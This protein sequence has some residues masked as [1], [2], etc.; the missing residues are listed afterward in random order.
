MNERKISI[1]PSSVG[2]MLFA[3]SCKDHY[4]PPAVKN[5][6]T[7]LVVDGLLTSYPDTAS[8]TLTSTRNLPDSTP[9][10]P[11]LNTSVLEAPGYLFTFLYESNN[12]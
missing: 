8:I 5:N 9:G 6:P 4:T 10:Q 11:E 12:G 2:I 3:E 7:Y 1:V